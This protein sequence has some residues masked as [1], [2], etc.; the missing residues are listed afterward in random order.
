M[1]R[2]RKYS[3][4]WC[5]S[6]LCQYFKYYK[7]WSHLKLCH[8]KTLLLGWIKALSQWA[9]PSFSSGPMSISPITMS[10]EGIVININNRLILTF[11]SKSKG[12]FDLYSYLLRAVVFFFIL[13]FISFEKSKTAMTHVPFQMNMWFLNTIVHTHLAP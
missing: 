7:E 4:I 6:I 10:E 11:C 5:E 2:E 12:L 13:K 3:H 8:I 1:K 9:F